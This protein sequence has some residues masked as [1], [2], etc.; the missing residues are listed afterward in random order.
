MQIFSGLC[1]E[2]GIGFQ[3]QSQQIRDARHPLRVTHCTKKPR[4]GLVL[5]TLMVNRYENALHFAS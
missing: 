3:G 5:A 1:A 4:D 2:S